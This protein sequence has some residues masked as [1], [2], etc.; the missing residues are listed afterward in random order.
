M[1]LEQPLA[2]ARGRA[3][4]R[5]VVDDVQHRVRG[6]ADTTGPPAKVEPWSPGREDVVR[7]RSPM[8]SA[9]IGRPPPRP[10]ASVIA[11][12]HDAELLVGPQRAGAAHAGLHL[13]EDQRGADRVARLPDGGQQLGAT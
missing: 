5:L 7:A 10:L 12:G 9:P 11:S 6:D 3:E 1:P 8:T 2:G 13:V 4:E